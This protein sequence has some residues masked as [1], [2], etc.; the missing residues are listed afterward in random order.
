MTL[1]AEHNALGDGMGIPHLLAMADP[2]P[3]RLRANLTLTFALALASFKLKYAG[4]VLG[5]LWSL[6]KPLLL[7]GMM[8]V[9]FAL[10]LLRGRTAPGENFPVELLFG[11]VIWTFFADATASSLQAIVS[12]GDMIKK[13]YF[14]RWILVVAAGLSSAMT[15]FVNTA[16]VLAIGLP[17]HWFT[18]GPESALLIP[19]YLELFAVTL[20]AG[21]LLSAIFVYARDLG[22]IWE[23]ILQAIFY[24]SAVVFPFTLIPDRFQG[25][26]ALSPLTQ[27]IED[28]RRAFISPGIPWTADVLGPRFVVPL[29]LAVASLG[30]GAAVFAR[31]SRRFGENI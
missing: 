1:T 8:Y 24:A 6:V 18:F 19:L 21:L 3:S 31:L 12:N 25:I 30:I 11:I 29:M 28:M 23:I 16:L 17:L 26:V 27:M 20:G 10:F 14:P 2:A 7:F 15:L 5:Y 13:A 9:V 4:S 22:H